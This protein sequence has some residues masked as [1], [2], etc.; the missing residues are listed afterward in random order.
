MSYD[1]HKNTAQIIL[2]NGGRNRNEPGLP[3]IVT[4]KNVMG[5]LLFDMAQKLNRN[6]DR[7]APVKPITVVKMKSDKKKAAGRLLFS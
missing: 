7:A 4:S 1:L 6:A 2:K 3:P 5:F